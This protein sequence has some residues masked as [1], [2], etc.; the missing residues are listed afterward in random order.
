M[1][2][3]KGSKK[4]FHYDS[5]KRLSGCFTEGPT[6]CP[7]CLAV[8]PL[9][10]CWTGTSCCPETGRGSCTTTWS[11]WQPDSSTRSSSTWSS[12]WS[13][14]S[15]SAGCSTNRWAKTEQN[16]LVEPQEVEVVHL[17]DML[18]VK[19]SVTGFL[20]SFAAHC[21]SSLFFQYGLG[22]QAFSTVKSCEI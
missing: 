15:W 13:R 5:L 8:L 22:N 9:Q 18:D 20:F 16:C 12:T 4:L 3:A 2:L 21:S 1:L 14:T 17:W 7:D 10:P 11:W 19:S 6:Q